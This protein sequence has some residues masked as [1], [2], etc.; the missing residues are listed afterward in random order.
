MSGLGK[1]DSVKSV[2]L[3]VMKDTT[4]IAGKPLLLEPSAKQLKPEEE[5]VSQ[6]N[7]GS[8]VLSCSLSCMLPWSFNPE[9]HRQ[10]PGAW[11]STL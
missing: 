9:L 10:R 1:V 2:R 8:Q 6:D 5:R 3:L 7:E 4:S 11:R